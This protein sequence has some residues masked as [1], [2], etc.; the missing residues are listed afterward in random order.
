MSEP[1]FGPRKYKNKLG[2]YIGI[3]DSEHYVPYKYIN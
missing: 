1:H 2:V 3:F